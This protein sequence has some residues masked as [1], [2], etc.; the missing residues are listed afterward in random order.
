VI[1]HT[2]LTVHMYEALETLGYALFAPAA[3]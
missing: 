3:P 1:L 2:R